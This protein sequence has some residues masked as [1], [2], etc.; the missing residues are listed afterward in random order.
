MELFEVMRTTFAA[1]DYT[2]DPLP[3]AVLQEMFEN[4]RFAPSGGNRQGAR[5]I[6]VRDKA[7]KDRL[8]DLAEPAGKRYMAQV[9]AGEGPWNPLAPPGVSD[10]TIAE[11]TRHQ[12]S[13]SEFPR[14]R[15]PLPSGKQTSWRGLRNVC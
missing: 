1:R 11:T 13:P 12:R 15:G 4:A 6:V 7:T 8:A 10:A 14:R 3:D 2:S 5:V 9:A